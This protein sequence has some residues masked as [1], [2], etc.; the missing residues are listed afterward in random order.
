M[1]LIHLIKK[2]KFLFKINYQRFNEKNEKGS[3]TQNGIN[4][5]GSGNSNF[6]FANI[7]MDASEMQKNEIFLDNYLMNFRNKDNIP[8]SDDFKNILVLNKTQ[9]NSNLENEVDNFIFNHYNEFKRFDIKELSE[10]LAIAS[11]LNF[12]TVSKEEIEIIESI[13]IEKM[14]NNKNSISNESLLYLIEALI[15]IQYKNSSFFNNLFDKILSVVI[16]NF[17]KFEEIEKFKLGSLLIFFYSMNMAPSFKKYL[18]K[19][20]ED[21]NVNINFTSESKIY[22]KNLF[23][24]LLLYTSY[25]NSIKN[26]DFRIVLLQI[27]P[28]M[29]FDKCLLGNYSKG[30]LFEIMN[31]NT[32][33][34]SKF[35]KN[36]ESNVN[37]QQ[38]QSVLISNM[39]NYLFSNESLI[40]SN[41]EKSVIYS[42]GLNNEVILETIFLSLREIKDLSSKDIKYI[43]V[44]VNQLLSSS[45]NG[46]FNKS[47]SLTGIIYRK[48]IQ[49]IDSSLYELS[50]KLEK[51]KTK[52]DNK[53]KTF[54]GRFIVFYPFSGVDYETEIEVIYKNWLKLNI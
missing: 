50:H 48:Q 13:F 54:L 18:L 30:E 32:E 53:F 3:N 37:N 52:I 43:N 49:E 40:R 8:S 28:K 36:L 41:L 7:S 5:F 1:K 25:I 12:N 46:S 33:E 17:H 31:K 26:N 47:K 4:S 6:N 11:S 9:F 21:R 23:D 45:T 29:V 2:Q 22:N 35:I 27:L 42:A 44:L 20:K 38:I 34:I 10:I 51:S 19:I 15:S 24:L 16:S 39:S 14:N